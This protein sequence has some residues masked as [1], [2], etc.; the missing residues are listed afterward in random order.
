MAKSSSSTKQESSGFGSV[1][2]FL[3][4]KTYDSLSPTYLLLLLAIIVILVII[5]GTK[6]L[7]WVIIILISLIVLLALVAFCK[8]YS[9]SQEEKDKIV[10]DAIISQA[11]EENIV[12]LSSSEREALI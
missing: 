6:L 9:T 10:L 5:F 7:G 3:C 11:T 12:K 1:C 8:Y 4:K 2:S